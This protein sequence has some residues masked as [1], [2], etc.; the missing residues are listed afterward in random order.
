M[1]RNAIFWGTLLILA[2]VVFLLQNL[3]IL[4]GSFWN[5][6]WPLVIIAIGVSFLWGVSSRRSVKAEHAKLPLEGARRARVR[7]RHGA[8]R[9][10]IHSGA[11]AGDLLE[12]DFG[13]GVELST[14]HDGDLL[15]ASLSM[16][17]QNFPFWGWSGERLDWTIAVARD[18]PIDLD[19]ETGANEARIDLADLLVTGLRLK[20]GASSTDLTL[21]AAAGFTRADVQTGAAAVRI[22]VPQ[23]VAARIRARGGLASIV[24]DQGRFP[25]AG[26]GYQSAD[27]EQAANKVD[28]NIETGVGSTEVR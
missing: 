15:D 18:L 25:R 13:G 26:D 19:L 1:R 20:S 9:L 7:I 12:G 21:P 14:R 24:V 6:F 4:S 5:I 2:G 8:G 28:L 27:Y 17:P 22:N 23:G 11:P 16:Q 3:G 10:D